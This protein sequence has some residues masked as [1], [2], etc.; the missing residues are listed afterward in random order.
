[1][2]KKEFKHF[3]IINQ[4][5]ISGG[6]YSVQSCGYNDAP[7]C[8]N[9][10]QDIKCSG[11]RYRG[12]YPGGKDCADSPGNPDDMCC[13][14][15]FPGGTDNIDHALCRTVDSP[16]GGFGGRSWYCWIEWYYDIFLH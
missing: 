14:G 5:A 9:P 10:S 4:S 2:G 8:T 6:G 11:E 15:H 12:C 3:K 7:V 16:W 1:M 13:F